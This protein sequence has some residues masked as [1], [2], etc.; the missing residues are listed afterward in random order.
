[1]EFSFRHYSPANTPA[2]YAP[3]AFAAGLVAPVS[4]RL[5]GFAKLLPN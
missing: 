5:L 4:A 3:A 1:M 2:P